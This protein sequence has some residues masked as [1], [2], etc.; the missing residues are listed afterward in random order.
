MI[1]S[2]EAQAFS[3]SRVGDTL[4][5]FLALPPLSCPPLILFEAPKHKPLDTPVLEAS[6]FSNTL[7]FG[8]A[9][10]SQ[11]VAFLHS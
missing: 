5:P 3:H 2:A 10:C 8:W 9:D 1:G 7:P 11:S 6:L 4:L